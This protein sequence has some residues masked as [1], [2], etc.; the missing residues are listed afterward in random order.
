MNS[1]RDETYFDGRPGTHKVQL[2]LPMI[3]VAGGHYLWN[4]R[5]WDGDSG[6]P[7]IDTP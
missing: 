2:S 7:L 1:G 4:I 3:P 5:M 6:V